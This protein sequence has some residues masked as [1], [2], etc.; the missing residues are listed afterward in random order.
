MSANNQILIKKVEGKWRATDEDVDCD[1]GHFISDEP[2]ET[3]EEAIKA[4]NDYRDGGEVEYG[5]KIIL[6]RQRLRA[7]SHGE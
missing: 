4:A 6:P 3:L 5:L 2:F 7:E 1:G